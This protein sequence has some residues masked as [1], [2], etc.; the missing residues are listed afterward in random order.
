MNILIAIASCANHLNRNTACLET[1][2]SPESIYDCAEKYI[3]THN[4]VIQIFT[5]KDLG[6]SDEYEALP[7]KVRAI[8]EYA[9]DTEFDVLLKCDSDTFVWLNRFLESGFAEYDY[10]GWTGGIVHPSE[11]YASGG[12]GYVLSRKAFS[13]VAEAPLTLDTA[14]DRWVGRVLYD[15]G[16]I[17]HRDTRYAHGFHRKPFEDNTLVTYHPAS[18]KRMMELWEKE[19][20]RT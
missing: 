9:H 12:A 14:E 19:K 13:I 10:V 17:V 2:A 1:W 6:V 18:P 5:G 20:S 3:G 4:L 11:E 16:I 8:C 7:A 15:G